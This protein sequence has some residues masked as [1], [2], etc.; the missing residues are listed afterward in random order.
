[1]DRGNRAGGSPVYRG[2][3]AAMPGKSRR[4]QTRNLYLEVGAPVRAMPTIT[5][6]RAQRVPH[7]EPPIPCVFPPVSSAPDSVAPARHSAPKVRVF[8][9]TEPDDSL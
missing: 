2:T 8:P 4:R 1:S 5:R 9:P 3:L 7:Q 6:W